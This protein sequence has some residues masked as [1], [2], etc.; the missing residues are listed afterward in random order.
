MDQKAKTKTA[1]DQPPQL[2]SWRESSSRG[3]LIQQQ[4]D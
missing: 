3:T 4:L 1:R 2:L